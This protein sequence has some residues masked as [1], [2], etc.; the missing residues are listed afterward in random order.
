MYVYEQVLHTILIFTVTCSKH[1]VLVMQ[2]WPN[3]LTRGPNM[4]LS[5][6]W[7]AGYSAI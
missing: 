6:L 3:V 7:R 1:Y 5:G 2:G 4:Q